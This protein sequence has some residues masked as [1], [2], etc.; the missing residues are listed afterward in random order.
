MYTHDWGM[1]GIKNEVMEKG[2]GSFW[3]VGG[4]EFWLSAKTRRR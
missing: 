4:S 3:R 1:E 2:E